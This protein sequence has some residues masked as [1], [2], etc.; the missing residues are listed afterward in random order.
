MGDNEFGQLG[1]TRGATPEENCVDVP[2]HVSTFGPNNSIKQIGCGDEFS[3]ALTTKGE[4]YSW[5]RGQ[6]GQLGLGD[7]QT[8]PL[9]TPTK[10][11]NLPSIQKLAV[12]INQVFAIEFTD[13]T[14]TSQQTVENS[15]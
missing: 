10:V 11:P 12:G 7:S 14:S 13:G 1:V 8:G 9:D 2:V 3:M 15:S 6:L 5:G 4:V